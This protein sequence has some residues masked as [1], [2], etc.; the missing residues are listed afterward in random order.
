MPEY[1]Y[2]EYEVLVSMTVTAPSRLHALEALVRSGIYSGNLIGE[3]L[4]DSVDVL[5]DEDYEW[6]DGV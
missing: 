4:I 5:T 3:S 6:V 1:E 2:K